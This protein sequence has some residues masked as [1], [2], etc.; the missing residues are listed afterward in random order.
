MSALLTRTRSVS[1]SRSLAAAATGCAARCASGCRSM[2]SRNHA[3]RKSSRPNWFWAASPARPAT[4][5]HRPRCRPS[6]A[7]SCSCARSD[8]SSSITCRAKLF[9]GWQ[10]HALLRQL[11]LDAQ[12]ALAHFVVGHGLGIDQRHDVVDRARR[13]PRGRSRLALHLASCSSVSD[14]ATAA[15]QRRHQAPN[16]Q[17]DGKVCEQQVSWNRGRQ[18]YVGKR[19]GGT[20]SSRR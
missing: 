10:S 2:P 11:L 6:S 17:R 13:P 4:A 12:Q 15:S 20:T 14:C 5:T 7:A 8:T 3:R 9:A 18:S 16:D 1:R 19:L